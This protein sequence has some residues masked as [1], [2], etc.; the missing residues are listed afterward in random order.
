[1]SRFLLRPSVDCRNLASKV[2]SMSVARLAVDFEQRYHYT[3]YLIESFVDLEGY[4]GT[5]YQ[6]ANWIDIGQTK[7]RGRQDRFT[8]SELSRKGIYVYPLNREFRQQLGLSPSAGSGALDLTKLLLRP[9]LGVQ[10]L[11]KIQGT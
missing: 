10:S 8:K 9:L 7:G 4:A 5:C 11:G 3:P 2:L 6:A 1:M